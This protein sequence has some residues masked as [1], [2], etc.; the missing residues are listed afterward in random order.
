MWARL[1]PERIFLLVALP[2]GLVLLA[3][4]PP[5]AGGNETHNF[6][7]VAG[8]VSGEILVAP[9]S[10]PAGVNDVLGDTNRR[11]PEGRSPPYRYRAADWEKVAAVELQ[12][13][14]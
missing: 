8:I 2:V 10:V 14:R 12:R 13:E 4:I 5:L 3:L 1:S 11:F 9:V 7:R 6:R